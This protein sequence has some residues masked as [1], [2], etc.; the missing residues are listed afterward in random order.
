[1]ADFDDED[2]G[3]IVEKKIPKHRIEYSDIKDEDLMVTIIKY[4]AEAIEGDKSDKDA[5]T[6][7]KKSLD[8]DKSLNNPSNPNSSS[9]FEEQGVW[10]VVI[11]KQFVGSI[12]FDAEYLIYFQ[13]TDMSKYF[14]IFRS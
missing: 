11:G 14:M 3:D 12:T 1:M 10:Q 8:Q 9:E 6:I 2:H 5:A 13:F 4:A 7:L